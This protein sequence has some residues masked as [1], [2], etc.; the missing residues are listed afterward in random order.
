MRTFL[1]NFPNFKN[2][3]TRVESI[4]IYPE[5]AELGRPLCRLWTQCSDTKRYMHM[6]KWSSQ[7]TCVWQNGIAHRPDLHVFIG[8][9]PWRLLYGKFAIY[10]NKDGIRTSI[11]MVSQRNRTQSDALGPLWVLFLWLNHTTSNSHNCRQLFH[12][13]YKRAYFF[14]MSIL[15]HKDSLRDT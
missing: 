5:N 8:H 3:Q 4:E 12:Y 7:D 15:D 1:K 14:K 11:K 10:A 13:A 9:S 2:V 6:A